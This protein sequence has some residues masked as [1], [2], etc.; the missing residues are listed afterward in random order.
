MSTKAQVVRDRARPGTGLPQDLLAASGAA[1]AAR[2]KDTQRALL[3]ILEDFE[4]EKTD[5]ESGQHG[6]LNILEDFDAEKR[7][8]EGAQGALLNILEDFTTEKLR[9]EDTQRAATNILEDFAAEKA[10]LEGTQRAV[11]NI[12]EDFDVAKQQVE[13][14]NERLTQEV[15]QR[16]RAEQEI[17][18]VNSELLAANK[19]LEAFTYSV[20][21]DLRAPLRSIDGFGLALVEDYADKLDS[22]GQGHLQRVRAAAQRMAELI[23]G[24]L[25]LSRVTRAELRRE[26]VDLTAL[27]QDVVEELRRADPH[28]PLEVAIG[29]ALAAQGDSRLLRGV[30]QNLLGNAWKFT[31]RNPQPKIEFGWSA[32]TPENGAFFVRDNGDGFDMAYADKLFAPF[33]R[34]HRQ[35]EFPGTGVGLA[36]VQRVILRHGGSIWAEGA[37][38]RGATFYFTLGRPEE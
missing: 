1:E 32:H 18:R 19:E 4:A 16:K 37:V 34:L 35:S 30:L 31:S 23:E 28:R 6:V 22:Q 14:A 25:A 21:H 9:L 27:A 15:E 5:L 11:L 3:N 38:G 10:Q 20:A 36:T 7:R 8:L 12:L 2:L 17:H 26:K 13:S 24:L 33:Q 29:K